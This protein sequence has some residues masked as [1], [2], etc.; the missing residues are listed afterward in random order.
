[1]LILGIDP[2][3]VTTGYGLVLLQQGRL[4]HMDNGGIFMS[5][6][7]SLS[8]RVCRI[9]DG[10]RDLIQKYSPDALALEDIFIAKNVQ[11][12]LKLGHARGAVMVA[13][14]ASRLPLFE[15]T[16]LQV[17]Q[18]VTGYGNAPKDQVARMIKAL[19]SLPDL[20]FSDASDALAVAICH[21]HSHRLLKKVRQA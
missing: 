16:A 15:Y 10:I 21:S 4:K 11:S 18:A 5:S 7:E 14:G 20:A 2:G 17:K 3:S 6:R 19:L 9:H 1:M 13:A 12:T 8:D